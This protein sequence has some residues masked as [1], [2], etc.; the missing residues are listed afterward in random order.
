MRLA[1]TF[2]LLFLGSLIACSAATAEDEEVASHADEWEAQ[3]PVHAEKSTHLWIV[4]S[5]LEVL[6]RHED[7]RPAHVIRTK[8]TSPTCLTA[9]EQGLFD[10]DFRHEY[11]N[12]WRD[13]QPGAS[14][15]E[16]FLSGTSWKSHFFDPDTGRNYKG[17][18][19]P[20]AYTEALR[21][22]EQARRDMNADEAKG[23]YALG[24]S[25]HYMTDLTQPMHAANF[26]ALSMPTK[27]HSNIETW[28]LTV[29]SSYR[30]TDWSGPPSSS[31]GDFILNL[32]RT[33]KR[34]WS[35]SQDVID[36]AY[37]HAPAALRCTSL[38]SRTVDDPRCWSWDPL[39]RAD[40]GRSLSRAQDVTAQYL[41]IAGTLLAPAA[42]EVAS[43]PVEGGGD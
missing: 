18:R 13:L 33:S 23:C 43:A 7:L 38:A 26:T 3:S 1:R 6:G 22:L 11:N 21:F 31:A 19:S 29:Q 39:V 42:T 34:M 9:W 40:L 16:I 41:F 8:M 12:G 24:L 25:L 36:H 15:F 2:T 14:A 28:A 37:E 5:A 35:T 20:T 17:D 10:A 30:V 4:Q 27:L 32:A